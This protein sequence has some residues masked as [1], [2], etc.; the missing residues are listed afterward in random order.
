MDSKK[1]KHVRTNF[2]NKE[3]YLSLYA[4]KNEDAIRFQEESFRIQRLDRSFITISTVLSI[5]YLIRDI[6]IRHRYFRLRPTTIS[7][8]E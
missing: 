4:T 5:L 8:N 1:L 7:A 2:L 3:S 6:V